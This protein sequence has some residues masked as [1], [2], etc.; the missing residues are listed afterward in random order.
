MEL[1]RRQ[2][3]A[4]AIGGVGTAS[5]SVAAY[6]VILGYGRISGTNLL[7]Q[8]LDPLVTAEFEPRDGPLGWLGRHRV[9]LEQGDVL[10]SEDGTPIA[11]FPSD[12]VEGGAE[13]DAA[14]GRTNEPLQR[15]AMDLRAFDRG[16]YT[17][18]YGDYRWFFDRLDAGTPRGLTVGAFRGWMTA[19][20][21]HVSAV[22]RADPADPEATL[23]GLARG[24][25]RETR[26]DLPRYLAG[27][28]EDNVLFGGLD[29]RQHFESPTDF[30][31]IARG[32]DSGLFC[33]ELVFRSIE[34]LQAVPATEQSPP[35]VAGYVRN[36]RHKHA[37]TALASVLREN[38]SV[39]IP[40]TFVDYT[41]AILYDDLGLRDLMGEGFDAYTDRQRAT[42]IHWY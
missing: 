19:D 34:A 22:T 29:L 12:D 23:E 17:L 20:P 35:V 7:E 41:R 32:R 25:R 38:G 14:I 16:A 10:V 18:E 11:R 6:N 8:D 36:T 2:V 39:V 21:S 13:A 42:S 37:F 3:L 24:L 9:S 31:A 33:Y 28:I 27:S 26:Y 5:A 30:R 1:S 40:V 15:L 4:G